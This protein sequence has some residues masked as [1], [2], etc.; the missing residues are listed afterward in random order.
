MENDSG[1]V[2]EVDKFLI[3]GLGNPGLQ[4]KLTRHNIGFKIVD[5][6]A[7]QFGV[8]L[9]KKKEFLAEF[10]KL[11]LDG[12]EV[13]LQKPQTF[14]NLSGLSVQKSAAF[15]RVPSSHILVIC[16][17]AYLEFGDMRLRAKGSSGGHNG[18]KSVQESL[19]TEHYPRLRFGVGGSAI[20]DLE[21]FVLGRFTKDEQSVLEEFILAACHIVKTW[22]D[23][24]VEKATECASKH[25]MALIEKGK[26]D[27]KTKKTTL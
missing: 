23:E 24:G 11:K 13:F 26:K 9:K 21:R 15:Y 5:A 20:Q 18:L 7:K 16:D 6:L 27:E 25:K 4:Y 12:K 19:G 17:E 3:V 2:E 10:V 22:V 8:K 14:M 1:R